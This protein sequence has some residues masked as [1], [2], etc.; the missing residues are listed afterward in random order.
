MS[1]IT[2]Q[3]HARFLS[4]THT[5]D[6]DEWRATLAK[7]SA[8]NRYFRELEE[9]AKAPAKVQPKPRRRKA[10]PKP[11]RE[12]KP[13]AARKPAEQ[14]IRPCPTC[15]RD[16]RPDSPVSEKEF[17]DL[18]PRKSKGL[19]LRCYRRTRHKNQNNLVKVRPCT[20]CGFPT[21][22]SHSPVADFPG[23]RVRHN[24]EICQICYK[25]DRRKAAAA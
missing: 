19:C 15:G 9:A 3:S 22:P 14:R 1:V 4:I 6:L 8:V 18:S 2:D 11:P 5:T 13:R 25:R 16:T 10:E 23:T 20:Q 21:R 12:R 24:A 17:P 7:K